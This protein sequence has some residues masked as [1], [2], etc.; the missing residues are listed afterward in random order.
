MST[1][2]K[3]VPII[4]DDDIWRNVTQLTIWD[5]VVNVH[6][7]VPDFN[8]LVTFQ[9]FLRNPQQQNNHRQL[10]V[11]GFK[12]EERM[13]HY[14]IVWLLCPRATNHAQ[15][16]EQDLLLL[17]GILNHVHIDWP[18]LIADTM[19]KDDDNQDEEDDNM[20]AH[21]AE[22]VRVAAPCEVGPSTMPSSLFSL[23]GRQTHQDYV[24]ERLE[25]FDTRLGNIEELLNL[26]PPEHPPSPT[27]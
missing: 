22:P 27:F 17:Y 8:P 3:E 21:M 5:D 2:V 14:L 9:S 11:G 10:L 25:D 15:C 6:L 7:G 19:L 16:S 13:I 1:K 23:N 24:Y 12:V 20:D 18:A 26:Q 4:L